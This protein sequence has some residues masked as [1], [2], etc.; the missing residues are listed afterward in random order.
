MDSFFL[1]QNALQR[2]CCRQV[3]CWGAVLAFF[4]VVPL[5]LVQGADRTRTYR[6]ETK[7]YRAVEVVYKLSPF[8]LLRVTVYGE[9]DLESEQR[10]SDKG[11]LSVP[12]VGEVPVGGLTVSEAAKKIERSFVEQ[13]YLRHPIITISIKEFAPKI[14][15]VLG[16]VE[17]PGSIEIPPG[18]NGIPVQIAIA[19]AGGFTGTAKT[20]E[21]NVTRAAAITGQR[22][23]AVVNVDEMLK[24]KGS[25]ASN[26]VFL[27]FPDDVIYVPRRVF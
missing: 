7:V 13:Q 14:V 8:D 21:V 1:Y 25:S 11:M 23:R 9:K 12:L 19:G 26:S 17:S 2:S 6:S 10:I 18:R 15:T 20:T 16:E 27:V 5:I 22:G 24:S 3:W 4:F